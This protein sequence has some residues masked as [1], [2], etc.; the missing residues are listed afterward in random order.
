MNSSQTQQPPMALWAHNLREV[1][2]VT[3][4]NFQVT[5]GDKC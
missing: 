5:Y 4:Q 2:I 3:T 1:K